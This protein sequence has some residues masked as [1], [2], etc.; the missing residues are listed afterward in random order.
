MHSRL[1]YPLLICI[2]GH[3]HVC[4]TKLEFLYMIGL[5]GMMFHDF[6]TIAGERKT[7]GTF[8]LRGQEEVATI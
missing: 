5:A 8:H 7:L 4:N 6:F 2:F 1:D 3:G